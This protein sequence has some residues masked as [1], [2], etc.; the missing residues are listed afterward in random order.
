MIFDEFHIGP[1]EYLSN[2]DT[3]ASRFNQKIKWEKMNDV[4]NVFIAMIEFKHTWTSWPQ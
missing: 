2:P 4:G 3:Q 1:S